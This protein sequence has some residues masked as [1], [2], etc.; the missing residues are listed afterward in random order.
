M[1]S[2]IIALAVITM[3]AM[4]CSS[5]KTEVEKLE[6]HRFT[7]EKIANTK[8]NAFL[9]D[10][11]DSFLIELRNNLEKVNV[12]NRDYY[13]IEGDILMDSAELD[14]YGSERLLSYL[15]DS[16][17][18]PA[19]SEEQ[20]FTISTIGGIPELWPGGTTLT[21]AIVR[22]SF[23]SKELYDSTVKFM[24]IAERSWMDASNIHFK[25]LEKYDTASPSSI[26]KDPIIFYVQFFDKPA[27]FV[28]KAFFPNDSAYRRKVL[29]R[30]SLFSPNLT[31]SRP[32]IL[33]HELG[34]ILGA[35]HEHI[36]SH[37]E[38]CRSESLTIRY[39]S[40]Q[41]V[42]EY[43]PYS[44]MHYLCGDLG[45]RTLELT[46]FDIAGIQKLYGPKQR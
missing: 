13:V 9:T 27:T 24:Q 19:K 21:Y 22:N 11:L 28:A 16:T 38:K 5:K 14:E 45:S 18:Y 26:P 46:S 23:P 7:I 3:S 1:R 41:Q 6:T 44:V 32:G 29:V 31:V 34:H 20:E 35:R 36:W 12:E 25:H 4:A 39:R 37:V 2:T 15:Y 33:R 17:L 42:T 8:G 30:P 40:A 10:H 43:D